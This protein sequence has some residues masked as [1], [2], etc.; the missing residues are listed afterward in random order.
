MKN[1]LFAAGAAIVVALSAAAASAGQ[2]AAPTGT[3]SGAVIRVDDHR[4]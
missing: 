3:A 2:F 4:Y 1:V